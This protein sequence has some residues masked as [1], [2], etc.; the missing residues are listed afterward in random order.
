MRPKKIGL[1]LALA[2][3]ALCCETRS[4]HAR[5]YNDFEGHNNF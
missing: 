5:R 3:L 4:Y 2:G 1:S